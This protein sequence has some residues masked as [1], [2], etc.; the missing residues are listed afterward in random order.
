MQFLRLPGLLSSPI[1]VIKVRHLLLAIWMVLLIPAAVQGADNDQYA[2]LLGEWKQ[3]QQSQA[4][5]LTPLIELCQ[6]RG[7]TDAAAQTQEWIAP[8]NSQYRWLTWLPYE[9]AVLE[10]FVKTQTAQ[11]DWAVTFAADRRRQAGNLFE[12]AQQAAMAG[13]VSLAFDLL[14]AAA[15]QDPD[16]ADVRRIF[17]FRSFRDGWYT[18]YEIG[19]LQRGRI[20]HKQFGWIPEMHR[21]RYEQGERYDRGRWIPADRDAQLHQNIG[22][23]WTIDT[24][25]FRLT[26]NHSLEIGAE[27]AARLERLYQAWRQVYAEYYLS[28]LQVRQIFTGSNSLPTLGRGRR[29]EVVYFRDRNDYLETLQGEVPP[30]VTTSGVYLSRRKT[31]YFYHDPAGDGTTILH[32]ATHQLFSESEP[33]V[34]EPGSD[35]NFWLI[36]GAACY[37]ESLLDLPGNPKLAQPEQL[38][39]GGWTP[40]RLQD[41]RYY[42]LKQELSVPARELCS[43]GMLNLQRHPRI[44]QLYAQSAALTYLL[45]HGEQGQWR[46]TCVE[47]LKNI[48]DGKDR[49]DSLT[50]L[51]GKSWE[52]IDTAYKQFMTVQDSDLDGVLDAP[53]I[54]Y[55]A[56]GGTAVTD[57]GLE[58]LPPLQHVTWVD[59]FKTKVDGSG[60]VHLRDLPKLIQVDVSA[61]QITDEHLPQLA[62]LKQLETVI[63][64]ATRISNNGLATLAPLTSLKRLD[65]WNTLIGDAGLANVARLNSLVELDLS[66]SQVT[67]AGLVQ[68]A[69]LK[70]LRKLNVSRTA[71]TAAGVGRLKSQ[72]PE[73][74]VTQ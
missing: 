16:H 62:Q 52:E 41:A 36:E 54:S 67:D 63:L 7:W 46:G 33:T 34:R 70:N 40:F 10:G 3:L 30:N 5:R 18:Q 8:R 53:N 15:R 69:T 72:L 60:L 29:H 39:V 21:E 26:T 35:A 47:L 19:N 4:E 22:N 43:L 61:T 66:G 65:L 51:T 56:L 28:P 6:T 37:M 24:E 42:L 74:E 12:L 64:G 71:V 2:A 31:A 50:S 73:L 49:A 17:G 44:V 38:V 1:V 57:A 20:W 45:M 27:L 13:E 14:N 48:Y 59:L 55:L 68:L 32:E 9:A 58:E 23:G 11:A 25:H